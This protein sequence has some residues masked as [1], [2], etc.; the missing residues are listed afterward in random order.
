MPSASSRTTSA[1]FV[2]VFKPDEPVHDVHAR[3]FERPCPL[4]V[5]LLVD[6]GPSARRARPPACPRSAARMSVADDR[7]VA[8]RAVQRQLDGEHLRVGRR[9]A[10]ELLDRGGEALVRV[11]HEHVALAD[12]LED[13]RLSFL[14]AA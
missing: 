10:D 11:V 2:C 4:D 14:A 5:G 1:V 7:A 9:L 3:L 12:R 8:R 6:R 13:V